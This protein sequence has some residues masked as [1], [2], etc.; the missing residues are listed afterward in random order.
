MMK[1][2]ALGLVLVGSLTLQAAEIP[3]A[4]AAP[5]LDEQLQSLQTPGNE[6]PV[7]LTGEQLYAVQTRYVPLRLRHELAIGGASNF[8]GD[9]FLVSR[10]IDAAYRLYLTDRWF[11]GL[12]GN[13]VFND[14]SYAGK[15][16]DEILGRV[17]DVTIVKQR[18]DLQ[19]GFNLFYGKF[20]ASMDRVFYFDQYIGLGPGIAIM[21]KGRSIAVVGDVGFAF[22]FGRNFGLRVG[23]KDYFFNEL[24]SVRS[25]WN[26]NVLGYFQAGYVFGG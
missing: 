10:S 13:Y 7:G 1:K 14:L 20:R 12:S 24:R 4:Q 25:G 23:F 2:I 18:A 11:V 26:H 9:S 3:P 8:T 19:V 5:S 17:P 15:D 16:A 6:A 22:W 21:D